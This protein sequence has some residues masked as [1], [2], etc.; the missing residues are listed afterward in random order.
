M[1]PDNQITILRVTR[2]G[3]RRQ[4]HQCFEL[5]MLEDNFVGNS[6]ET[7]WNNAHNVTD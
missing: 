3:I 2:E 6:T 5:W 1:D 7:T 4:Y